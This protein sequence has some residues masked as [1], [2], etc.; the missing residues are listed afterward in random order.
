MI[1]PMVLISVSLSS[2]S[3][4]ILLGISI[5]K[6]LQS[7]KNSIETPSIKNKRK[8]PVVRYTGR[9]AVIMTDE[10]DDRLIQMEIEREDE[11]VLDKN[12]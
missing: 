12:S 5:V 2:F 3:I 8:E 7:P 10:R 11:L 6:L 9:P 1:G 4:G